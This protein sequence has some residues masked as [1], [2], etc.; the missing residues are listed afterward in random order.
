MI[1]KIT[2][3]AQ[4]LYS[5]QKDVNPLSKLPWPGIN[6]NWTFFQVYGDLYSKS[7]EVEV[8]TIFPIL[9]VVREIS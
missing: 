4:M 1:I 8:D 7:S 6:F 3:E 2:S 9:N 5:D